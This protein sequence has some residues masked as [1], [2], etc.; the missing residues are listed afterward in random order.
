[1]PLIDMPMDRLRNYE[2]RNPRPADFDAYWE[3]ALQE[4]RETDAQWEL[5]ASDFQVPYADCY[6][7]YFTGTGGARIHAKYVRPKHASEPHPAVLHFHGYSHYSGDWSDKLAWAL[8]GFSVLALDCRGQGGLSEDKGG[9]KGT[10]HRGHIIRG[11]DDHPDRLLFRDIF[12][13]TAKRTVRLLGPVEQ[14][15]HPCCRLRVRPRQAGEK[16]AN[17]VERQCAVHV[18]RAPCRWHADRPVGVRAQPL[19]R[20]AKVARRGGFGRACIGCDVAPCGSNRRIFLMSAIASPCILVCS[21]DQVT[22]YCFGCGR[23]KAEIG[24]WIEMTPETRQ[25]VMA[26]LPARLETVERKPRRETRRSRMAR[27]RN[28]SA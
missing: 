3:R 8:A 20:G 26:E 6:H 18:F 22:G 27:E 12:L 17:V 14:G 13:D 1:M 23:T 15:A 19:R 25:A 5:V 9:V 28:E 16:I 11:L 2:G 4:M 10:T 7:L 24:A 21:I